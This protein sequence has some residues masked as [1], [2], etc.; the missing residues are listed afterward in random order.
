MKGAK[1][2]TQKKKRIASSPS[3]IPPSVLLRNPALLQRLPEVESS[4]EDEESLDEETKLPVDV[5]KSSEVEPTPSDASQTNA[6]HQASDSKSSFDLVGKLRTF[7]KPSAQEIPPVPI[8]TPGHIPPPPTLTIP[9][10]TRPQTGDRANVYWRSVPLNDLRK[11]PHFLPLPDPDTISVVQSPKVFYLFRQ[12]S[13]QW[14]ALHQGRLT[15]SKLAAILGFYEKATAEYLDISQSLR[16]HERAVDA[17]NHIRRKPPAN[18]DHLVSDVAVQA[19]EETKSTSKKRNIYSQMWVTNSDAF[20]RFR[21]NYHPDIR[22]HA[23]MEKLA[24][25]LA[26]ANPIAARLAWGSAQEATAVLAALNYFLSHPRSADETVEVLEAGMLAIEAL[27]EVCPATPM[28]QGSTETKDRQTIYHELYQAMVVEKSL[29]LIGAS[30]DA[31]LRHVKKTNVSQEVGKEQSSH[32]SMQRIGED[33]EIEIV[34]VK[35]HSPFRTAHPSNPA[36]AASATAATSALPSAGGSMAV[37]LH[38]PML[39]SSFPLWH[40]PQIQLEMLCAGSRCNSA[41]VVIMHSVSSASVYR[42][43][44]D[45][46]YL[47]YLLQL[48]KD[49]YAR[50][51]KDKPSNR[52]KP[53][54]INFFQPRMASGYQNVRGGGNRKGAAKKTIPEIY[55]DFLKMTKNLAASA[56]LLKEL[57]Y[58]EIQRSPY[59]TKFFF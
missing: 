28:E 17:W 45:D 30:P 51:V 58:D 52:I 14:D 11:H 36:T 49:F 26:A 35:C 40:I 6:S 18:W 15:T 16:G 53:P 3:L 31:I 21:Y 55:T 32:P 2:K 23:S 34:E 27:D 12:E 38:K 25:R 44:R 48:V 54:E 10:D 43:A 20:G 13:W 59:N 8:L 50:F 37:S 7:L 24:T 46:L 5:S 1:R 47:D 42:I 39:H 56:V 4:S 29:P 9:L 22:Y 33:C 41:V 57:S 19:A